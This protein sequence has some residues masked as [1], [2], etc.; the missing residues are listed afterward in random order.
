MRSFTVSR[1]SGNHSGDSPAPQRRQ[2]L[3]IARG[4]GPRYH[5]SIVLKRALLFALILIP[6]LAQ[7]PS[8]APAQS[9]AQPPPFTSEVKEVLVPVTVTDEKGRFVSNLDAKDFRIFEE[10]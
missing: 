7:A 5:R 9:T 2:E 6:C 10:G 4:A 1:G 8:Q 3:P